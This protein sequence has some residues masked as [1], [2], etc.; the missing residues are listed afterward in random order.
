MRTREEIAVQ[1]LS[2]LP[3]TN[4]LM[5]ELKNLEID[6]LAPLE[7]LNKLYEWQQRLRRAQE[8]AEE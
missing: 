7:A 4:P 6:A 8:D 2:F 5:E 1:Q 3:T